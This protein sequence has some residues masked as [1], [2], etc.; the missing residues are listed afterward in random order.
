MTAVAAALGCA[1]Q[2]A[3]LPIDLHRLRSHFLTIPFA[4]THLFQL[5]ALRHI[6]SEMKEMFSLEKNARKEERERRMRLKLGDAFLGVWQ[7]C[8]EKRN[9]TF[10]DRNS[11][12]KVSSQIARA[13]KNGKKMN[14]CDVAS[15][16][17]LG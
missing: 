2:L 13:R 4:F 7:Q 15:G 8:G 5:F 11:R 6:T 12:E 9:V 1:C 16:G 3:L 17:V 10:G 14:E